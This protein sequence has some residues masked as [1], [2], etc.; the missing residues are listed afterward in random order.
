MDWRT[1]KVNLYEA[2]SIDIDLAEQDR[3]NPCKHSIRK[4]VLAERQRCARIVLKQ[5]DGTLY[6]EIAREILKEPK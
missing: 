1:I 3:L 4:A 2:E 6:S 5:D